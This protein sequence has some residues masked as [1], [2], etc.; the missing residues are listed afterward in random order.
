MGMIGVIKNP[1]RPTL[2]W[3]SIDFIDPKSNCTAKTIIHMSA[4][5]QQNLKILLC[6]FV[7]FRYNEL[8]TAP[9]APKKMSRMAA[10]DIS[11]SFIPNGFM[12]RF[13]LEAKV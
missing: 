5:K 9:V 7:F 1:K 8:R 11:I 13:A 3:M 6:C 12:I 2:N 4:P 10:I